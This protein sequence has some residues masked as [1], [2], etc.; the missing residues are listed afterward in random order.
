MLICSL[1]SSAPTGATPSGVWKNPKW[2]APCSAASRGRERELAQVVQ[3]HHA[4]RH[5]GNAAGLLGL[6]APEHV[7][8]LGHRHAKAGPVTLGCARVRCENV[9]GQR[10]AV[11]AHLDAHSD[12][13]AAAAHRGHVV[14]RVDAIDVDQLQREPETIA[15][16]WAAHQAHQELT[17]G[18]QAAHQRGADI[19]K[20]RLAGDVGSQRPFRPGG[21]DGRTGNPVGSPG[22]VDDAALQA[23]AARADDVGLNH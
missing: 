5:P 3:A 2:L 20:G 10:A 23:D 11:L 22:R 18:R 14:L 4:W 16:G 1:P 21:L 9:D 8:H 15:G 7:K 19:A 6:L 13:V 12:R 17:V